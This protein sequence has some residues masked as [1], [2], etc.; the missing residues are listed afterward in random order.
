[1]SPSR[2]R[3]RV[4]VTTVLLSGMILSGASAAETAADLVRDSSIRGGL[5]VHA[6][7]GDPAFTAALRVNDR[8]IVQGLETD[9]ARVAAARVRLRAAGVYGPVSVDRWDG[10]QLPY[11]DNLVN[12][13]VAET[14]VPPDEILR[15]LAP[16][17]VACTKKDGDW[18]KTVKPRPEDLDDWTHYLHGPDNNAVADDRAVDAP[19]H[20]QWTGG[21]RWARSHD[22]LATLSAAVTTGGRLFA[23]VDEGETF[24]VAMPARWRLVARDAF[25][26]VVLWKRDLPDWFAHLRPFRIGPSYLPRGLVAVGNR[27]YVCP[28]GDRPVEAL[29]A[30]TGKTIRTF[31]G[32]QGAREILVVKNAIHLVLHDLAPPVDWVQRNATEPAKRLLAIDADSGKPLW[33][34]RG[35]STTGLHSMTLAVGN[36]IAVYQAGRS[37]VCIDAKTGLEH[38]RAERAASASFKPWTHPTTVITRNSVLWADYHVP[39]RE[40]RKAGLRVANYGDLIVFDASN[41]KVRWR[42]RC[43]DD[44]RSPQEVYVIG[45]AVWTRSRKDPKE[46]GW[47]VGRDLQT[48]EVVREFQPDGKLFHANGHGWCYRNKATVRF[49]LRGRGGIDFLEVDTGKAASYHFTRGT[50]QYGILPANGLIYTPP[51]AC[52]CYINGKLNGFNA[53]APR[54]K[55]VSNQA[56]ASP[57]LEKG[58]AYES[59][60][61]PESGI[62]NRSAWP[63]YRADAS[64]ASHVQTTVATKP[65]VKWR[66][67]LK[68]PL[69]SPVYGDGMVCLAQIDAHT[70]HALDGITGKMIWSFTAGGRI[71]TPPT[72]HKGTALFGCAD[73]WLY[74]VRAKDGALAWR[75]RCAPGNRRLVA[76]GQIESVWPVPGSVLV[77]KDAAYVAAGRS[78]YLDGGMRLCKIDVR[79]GDLQAETTLDDRDPSTGLQKSG[80]PSGKTLTSAALPDVLSSD[81]SSVFLRQNR[82]DLDGKPQAHDVHHLFSSVGFADG[83]GWH[84]TYLLY[85]TAVKDGY[86]GWC[87]TANETAAGRMLA[88]DGNRIYGFGR[89]PPYGNSKHLGTGGVRYHLFA[90]APRPKVEVK[91]ERRG[92]KKKR[93]PV[94]EHAWSVESPVRARGLVLAGE[95]LYAAGPA[96]VLAGDVATDA[97]TAIQILGKHAEAFAGRKGGLLVSVSPADGRTLGELAVD[98]PPV[99]DGLIAADGALFMTTIDGHVVRME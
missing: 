55:G 96:N 54:R 92:D 77:M 6:G 72:I 53:L 23:V 34:K 20:L 83:A 36:G 95:V 68:G 85:G 66:V 21:P 84:R 48:G 4:A 29:D 13:L 73:G 78:S 43:H 1:M 44:F 28:G 98:S 57:R 51:H 60:R 63:T 91:V 65:A 26:G 17:G 9:P 82:F 90:S 37:L 88:F 45:D 69:T 38:W 25:S 58:P 19:H 11:I 62:R 7:G 40:E 79:T 75:F 89:K 15:V 35:E 50:C 3:G 59:I 87:S 30:A 22:H 86:G 94:K 61:N 10:K 97:S 56:N 27:V 8:Y 46:P 16:G 93:T 5:I 18:T 64:R 31:D 80:T 14:T 70:V 49:L 2:S 71:D 42:A 99:H 39:T 81:G 74:C 33:E 67:P 47:A 32:T 12:L 76:H 52:N 24:S 41:G